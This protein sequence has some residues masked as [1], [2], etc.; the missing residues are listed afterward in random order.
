QVRR[1]GPYP[2][3]DVDAIWRFFL[4]GL[5]DL[6]KAHAIDAV[7]ITTHGA[8]AALIDDDGA[9]ALPVLDYEHDGPAATAAAYDLLRPPFGESYSPRLPLGLN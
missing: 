5:A 3:Y 6:A 1:D 8:A 2:H 4:T 9:L 7:S